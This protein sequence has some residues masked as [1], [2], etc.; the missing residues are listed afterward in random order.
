[1]G[2]YIGVNMA[3]YILYKNNEVVNTIV[4][5]ELSDSDI[6]EMI[7]AGRC[8]S[9]ELL[10]VE[11]QDPVTPLVTWRAEDI[12]NGMTFAEKVVWDNNE[13]N[14]VVTVKQELQQSANTSYFTS[15]L[16]EMVSALIISTESKANILSQK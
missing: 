15:L 2:N 8:D 7:S 14:V 3:T 6:A 10:V 11:E 9:A 4:S 13:N 1:M 5:G 16:D 12:R